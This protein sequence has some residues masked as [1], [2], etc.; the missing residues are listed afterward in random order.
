M[1]GCVM[2]ALLLR[3][4][5]SPVLQSS[6]G[7]SNRLKGPIRYRAEVIQFSPDKQKTYLQNNVRVEYEDLVLTAGRV[8]ID[9]R[10]STLTAT[11]IADTTDSLGRPV[12]GQWPVLTQR[13]Q[14]PLRGKRL[15]YNFR[16]RRGRVLMGKTHLAQG[17]Y[18]GQIMQKVGEKTLFVRHGCFTT[19]NLAHP[20][21]YFCSDK[22]RIQV[23]KRAV[24]R[25]VVMYIADVPVM[26]VPFGIIPLE[27]GRHS[28]I[29][30]PTYGE[31]SVGGRYL[32]DFGY[33]WAAS[34]YWDLTLLGSFYENTGLVYR[35]LFRYNKRY[36][37]NGN[38]NV[39]YAPKDVLTGTKQ[40]RW[41]INFNHTQ[42]FSPTMSLSASGSFQ[43]DK[44]F[45]QDYF[46]DISQRLN[47]TLTTTVLLQKSFPG[48]R[49]NLNVNMRRTENLQTGRID[50]ELPNIR[51]TLPSR[52]LF[53]S[54]PGQGQNRWYQNITYSYTTNFKA[55]S[56]KDPTNS[57]ITGTRRKAAWIH[58]IN[59]SLN[60]KA[61]K[62][63]KW[64]GGFNFQEL[65]VPEYL[66]YTFVDSLNDTRAD[67]IS[68][69]R[70]RHTFSS[71]ISARSTIYGLWELPFL[72][73]K[74]IRHK[75]DP[76]ISFSFA[77]DF[78]SSRYGYFQT[79]R[80]TTGREI[81]R[82]RFAG[83]LFGSTP[84][85]GSQFLSIRVNNL[86]QTKYLTRDGR[87]KKL[88]LFRLNFSTAYNFRADSLNWSDLRTTFT[89]K[90]HRSFDISASATHTFYKRGA[91]GRGKR[92]RFVWS[93][94]FSLP[95]LLNWN[96]TLNGRFH[97]RAPQPGERETASPADT[98]GQDPFQKA[99]N[100]PGRVT[101]GSDP[102]IQSLRGF[103]VP[104]DVNVNFTYRYTWSEQS[105]GKQ[106][107]NASINARLQ[108]T[109]N[110]RINYTTQLDLIG[111]EIAYQQFS[112]YRDLHCWEMAFSWSPNPTFSFY[113]LEIRIKDALLRDIKLTKSS[114]GRPPF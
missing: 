6:P 27:R 45:R 105:G 102:Q 73:V 101:I 14:D 71:S 113:R 58:R 56:L 53:S 70:A 3:A 55:T 50:M 15:I 77:P 42:R 108:L 95:R 67:T 37:F 32:Q 107:W 41:L 110:W 75:M 61:F 5:P 20:H 21:Y 51:Y 39:S 59:S 83:N 78:S 28:G 99:V 112:I 30:I 106:Q 19:C 69:F 66:N 10:A 49:S 82:D 46:T 8:V 25:P 63:I 90:P 31:H 111:K 86:F 34:Q 26:G 4:Q 62:Y 44:R 92:N 17:Y 65:W 43:S 84:R 79:F 72:P 9:W 109:R 1:I 76:S 2:P 11:G 104:W 88:D 29:I 52:R 114:G 54:P 97:L 12:M 68:G 18:S 94:G 47:Q 40:Q 38:V 103:N 60:G 89:S 7:Q 33:Y 23:G 85:G 87:E 36:S 64:S 100:Q 24:V 13:G 48:S 98:A 93:D 16:T 80:D 81:K 74:V 35:G 96:V 22:V 91:G 57:A